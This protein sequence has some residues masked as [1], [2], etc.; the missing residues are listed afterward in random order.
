[1][2]TDCEFF[3]ECRRPLQVCKA[4]CKEY[5]KRKSAWTADPSWVGRVIMPNADVYVCIDGNVYKQTGG[6]GDFVAVAQK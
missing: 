2:K 4:T 3:D 5:V 1:M 6:V